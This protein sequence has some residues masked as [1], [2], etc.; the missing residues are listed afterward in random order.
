[1]IVCPKKIIEEKAVILSD[2]SKI[3]QSGIDVSINRI[4][5]IVRSDALKISYGETESL[6]STLQP[7][8]YDF[9]CH[10][11]VKVPE[12][13]TAVLYT[14]STFNRRGAFVTTGLYDNGFKNFIGGVLHVN[15]PLQLAANEMNSTNRIL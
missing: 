10:E 15:I 11:F 13:C 6:P 8:S 3:Q 1:M 12:N 2:F 5:L 4:S 7:G 14:R 9:I